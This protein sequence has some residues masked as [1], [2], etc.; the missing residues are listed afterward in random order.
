MLDVRERYESDYRFRQMVDMMESLIREM[1]FTPTEI[2]EAA[3][4]AQM[5]YEQYAPFGVRRFLTREELEKL[6]IE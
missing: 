2:R 5:K 3:M 1:E 4:L 6:K